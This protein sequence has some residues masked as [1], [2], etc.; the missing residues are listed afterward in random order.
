MTE[1]NNTAITANGNEIDKPKE[2]TTVVD[3]SKEIS[4]ESLKGS[5][6]AIAENEAK[7]NPKDS[8]KTNETPKNPL[9]NCWPPK[10]KNKKNR[11]ANKQMANY[12]QCISCFY[13]CVS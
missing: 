6:K 9:K 5:P 4:L 1:N 8:A 11:K 10:K 12:F 13:G 3:R 2:H 7:T